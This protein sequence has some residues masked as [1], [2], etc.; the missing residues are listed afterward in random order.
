MCKVFL[1][2]VVESDVFLDAAN[3]K[4]HNGRFSFIA[5]KEITAGFAIHETIFR[6]AARTCSFSKNV[7]PLFLIRIPIR[8]VKAHLVARQNLFGGSTQA[9][10]QFVPLRLI[11]CCKAAP[12]LNFVP[13]VAPSRCIY[14]DRNQ[15]DI[16]PAQFRTD[17]IHPETSF[18]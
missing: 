15:A 16:P 12:A 8:V 13:S 1:N 11:W 17:T 14:M 2:F 3:V 7:E 10:G 9:I 4:I 6:Q 5:Q 18:L